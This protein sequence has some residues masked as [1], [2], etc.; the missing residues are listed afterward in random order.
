MTDYTRI[1]HG[2]SN[3]P[4]VKSAVHVEVE[5]SS[6]NLL[7]FLEKVESD[8]G[9]TQGRVSIPQKTSELW[10]TVARLSSAPGLKWRQVAT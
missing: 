5:Q 4:S 10:D 6:P 8:S 7:K 2:N 3:S 9:L 1:S